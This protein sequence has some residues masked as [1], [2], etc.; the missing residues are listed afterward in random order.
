MTP[1]SMCA[2]HA[3]TPR[4]FKLL[5]CFESFSQNLPANIITKGINRATTLLQR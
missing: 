1:A 2:C 4:E 3:S 5:P